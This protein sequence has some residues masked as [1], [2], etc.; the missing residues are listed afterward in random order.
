MAKKSL[1]NK[2]NATPKFKV[3]GYTRAAAV[4]AL[5]P[6]FA[7]SASAGCAFVRWRTLARSRALPR[8]VGEDEQC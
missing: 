3:R 2:S 6:C 7:S 5:V 4:V 1:I 8:R